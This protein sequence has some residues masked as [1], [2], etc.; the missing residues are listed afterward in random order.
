M[1]KNPMGGPDRIRATSHAKSL[2]LANL[3]L[4]PLGEPLEG[5]R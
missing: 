1:R 2:C 3:A 5:T 4:T